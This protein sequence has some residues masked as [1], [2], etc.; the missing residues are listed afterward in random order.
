MIR[1]EIFL[2]VAALVFLIFGSLL[3]LSVESVVRITNLTNRVLFNIDDKIHTWRRSLGIVL[4]SVEY[5]FMVCCLDKMKGKEKEKMNCISL[6]KQKGATKMKRG[7]TLIELMIVIAVIAVLVGIS[8]PHFKGMQD[9]GNTA[10]AELRT[11]ATA[12]E[13]YYIHNSRAY[14]DQGESRDTDWQSNLTGASPKIITSVLYDPFIA[15]STEYSYATSASSNSQYYV[16]WSVGADGTTDITGVD[17]NGVIEGGPDD[18]IYI[19]NGTSGTG[20]F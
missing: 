20:G 8:L 19:S 16:V 11:L 17:P 13:S 15:G 5:L 12:I 4:F 2:I 1:M 7:F 14:P 3:L 9:E 6:K 10:K 18:D